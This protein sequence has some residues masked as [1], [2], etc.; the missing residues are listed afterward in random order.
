MRKLARSAHCQV[1]QKQKSSRN[2][3]EIKRSFRSGLSKT[4]EDLIIR[5]GSRNLMFEIFARLQKEALRMKTAVLLA[6]MS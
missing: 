2:Q 1:R 6:L 5:C 3:A 4:A